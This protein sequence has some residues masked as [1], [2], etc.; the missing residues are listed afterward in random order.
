[1]YTTSTKTSLLLSIIGFLLIQVKATNVA[2][3]LIYQPTFLGEASQPER[4]P[5]A[6]VIYNSN[7]DYGSQEAIFQTESR[8]TLWNYR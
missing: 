1:M 6:P 5:L 7:Y 2:T 4:I 8:R 3:G